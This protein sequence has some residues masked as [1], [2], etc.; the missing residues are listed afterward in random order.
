MPR[1][2]IES[3]SIVVGTDTPLPGKNLGPPIA[4]GIEQVMND[5]F[6]KEV[7][8]KIVALVDLAFSQASW[9]F[10][11]KLYELN[12]DKGNEATNADFKPLIDT[13]LRNP[14]AE[15]FVNI[16]K[17]DLKPVFDNEQKATL[18]YSHFDNAVKEVN[19]LLSFNFGSGSEAVKKERQTLI[20]LVKEYN[21]MAPGI[22]PEVREQV[23]AAKETVQ[24]KMAVITSVAAIDEITKFVDQQRKQFAAIESKQPLFEKLKGDKDFDKFK[25]LVKNHQEVLEI[26]KKT[27]EKNLQNPNKLSIA[28]V[29]KMI[30]L[31]NKKQE[32]AMNAIT[33]FKPKPAT[34]HQEEMK[35]AMLNSL[36]DLS[37][38]LKTL[39][40]MN[41]SDLQV[42]KG[43]QKDS[44]LNQ[45]FDAIQKARPD[46]DKG[47]KPLELKIE[48]VSEQELSTGSRS[49]SRSNS[50]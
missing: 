10:L 11:S 1:P 12:R 28:E 32:A 9:E 6:A 30:D 22:T 2:A 50:A 13:Y 37:K 27:L 45:K 38:Q 25:H 21:A 26:L 5:S 35:Q 46:V 40:A 34:P 16:H 48:E 7:K 15:S 44:E 8:D 42:Y 33:G 19:N 31:V 17:N 36:K 14:N 43:M 23:A 20:M 47:M 41:D 4:V 29:N 49:R 39:P 3:L 24:K 18:N